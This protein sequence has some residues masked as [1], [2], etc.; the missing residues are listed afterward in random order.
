MYGSAKALLH[1]RIQRSCINAAD[2]ALSVASK[3]PLILRHRSKEDYDPDSTLRAIDTVFRQRQ[4]Y[5][6]GLIFPQRCPLLL[7][8]QL[9]LPSSLGNRKRWTRVET[10]TGDVRRFVYNAFSTYLRIPTR[11]MADQTV[12]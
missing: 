10:L 6:V 11:V 2:D 3:P 12:F 1:L 9:S 5:S 7:A 4:T 8:K